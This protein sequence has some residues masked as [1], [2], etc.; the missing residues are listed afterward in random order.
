[1]V[2]N[3]AE[4]WNKRKMNRYEQIKQMSADGYRKGKVEDERGLCDVFFVFVTDVAGR[5][6][7]LVFGTFRPD[8][9]GKKFL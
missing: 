3:G 2:L 8:G 7:K 1:M 4:C 6:T 5:L 9:V